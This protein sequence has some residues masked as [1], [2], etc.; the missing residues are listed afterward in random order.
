MDPQGLS[1]ERATRYKALMAK[2]RAECL[3]LQEYEE[4]LSLTDEAER[5]Q[6]E[7]IQSLAELARLR[8]ISLRSLMDELNLK[9]TVND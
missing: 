5:L 7:R 4:L 1:P 3:T 8:G 6:V 9:P 2:R